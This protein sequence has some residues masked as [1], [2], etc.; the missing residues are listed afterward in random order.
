MS[1]PE[2]INFN[3]YKIFFDEALATTSTT[4]QKTPCDKLKDDIAAAKDAQTNKDTTEAEKE[5]AEKAQK[6]M[7]STLR[8]CCT[9]IVGGG[10][11]GDGREED[12]LGIETT[13]TT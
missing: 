1:V 3:L 13:T 2:K 12:K 11:K 6:N 4:K 8:D 5:A 9:P 7:E 10:G